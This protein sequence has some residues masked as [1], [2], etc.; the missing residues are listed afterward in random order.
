MEK[1][2]TDAIQ[3]NMKDLTMIKPGKVSKNKEKIENSISKSTDKEK[4]KGKVNGWDAQRNNDSGEVR[5]NCSDCNKVLNKKSIKKHMETVHGKMSSLP[6]RTLSD[7][8]RKSDD[9]LSP[10]KDEPV[11]KKSEVSTL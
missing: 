11:P 7:S 6:K 1:E 2:S 5:V 10:P 4:E 3:P 8:K 9:A